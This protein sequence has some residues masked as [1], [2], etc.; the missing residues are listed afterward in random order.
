MTV[1]QL[2][3]DKIRVEEKRHPF[4]EFGGYLLIDHHGCVV[5]IVFDMD[6][7]SSGD[8][9]LGASVITKLDPKR[10]MMVRGWFHKHPITGLSHTDKSTM[11]DLTEFWGE[12][13]TMVLQS[14]GKLLLIK[15]IYKE[16][17]DDDKNLEDDEDE[18]NDEKV[19]E[20]EPLQ[21]PEPKIAMD[22]KPVK[23]DE[24]EPAPTISKSRYKWLIRYKKNKN[25]ELGPKDI[26]TNHIQDGKLGKKPKKKFQSWWT[27]DVWTNTEEVFRKE[28][29]FGITQFTPEFTNNI[30]VV[31]LWYPKLKC[32]S[33]RQLS[34][35]DLMTTD[36]FTLSSSHQN[37]SI[38]REEVVRGIRIGQIKLLLS[39]G[40]VDRDRRLL[41]EGDNVA[42][43]TPYS[44]EEREGVVTLSEGVWKVVT[45]G[46]LLGRDA[47]DLS[48]RITIKFISDKSGGD[49]SD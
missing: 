14:N 25:K 47:S 24:P 38:L 15:T 27:P 21:E 45:R 32:I 3:L 18:H 41:F 1:S 30:R 39:S 34:Y 17:I 46:R 12:C 26:D 11:A 33:S 13:Y 28:I 23:D 8:V 31:K 7:Q 2:V 29:P 20:F 22:V 35:L 44:D 36:R 37:F 10:K 16:N 40:V 4:R 19:L 6:L 42:Y 9:D 48:D 5:D 43:L 49:D